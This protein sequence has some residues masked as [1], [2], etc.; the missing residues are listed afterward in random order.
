MNN[1]DTKPNWLVVGT[2]RAKKKAKTTCKEIPWWE[3]E[4][5]AAKDGVYFD[6][7]HRTWEVRQHGKP[8]LPV[9]GK[10]FN[11]VSTGMIEMY[12]DL[13]KPPIV[14]FKGSLS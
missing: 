10:L 8:A 6:K 14:S 1:A 12:E 11:N 7:V 5:P 2:Q 4:N 3:L 9:S 13:S